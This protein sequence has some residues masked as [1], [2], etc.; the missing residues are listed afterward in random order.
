MRPRNAWKSWRAKRL[1]MKNSALFLLNLIGSVALFNGGTAMSQPAAATPAA[2]VVFNV[3]DYGAVGDGKK[4]D[5]PAINKA[6]EACSVAG[7]GTVWVA[8]G[9]YLC[10]RIQIGRG[11]G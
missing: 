1:I 3:R 11:N 9:K 6:I 2:S 5:S 10:G 4:L 8:A 7:G